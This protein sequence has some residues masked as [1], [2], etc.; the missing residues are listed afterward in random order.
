MGACHLPWS[1]GCNKPVSGSC[2]KGVNHDRLCRCSFRVGIFPSSVSCTTSMLQRSVGPV[3]V[4]AWPRCSA[5]GLLAC[6]AVTH[7]GDTGHGCVCD[8][9]ATPYAAATPKSAWS[10]IETVHEP[11]REYAAAT[12]TDL[13]RGCVDTRRLDQT[14][15]NDRPARN[16]PKR[17]LEIT[18]PTLDGVLA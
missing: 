4:G 1:H 5:I 18:G 2:D 15:A 10:Q 14:A 6:A 7:P 8:S 17:R 12:P 9:P 13:L 3:G 16:S 11:D